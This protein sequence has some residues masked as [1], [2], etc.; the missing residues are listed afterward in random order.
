M[1]FIQWL[2]T[3]IKEKKTVLDQVFV[4]RRGL[5]VYHS[6]TY[7]TIIDRK[8]IY[9]PEVKTLRATQIITFIS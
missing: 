3:F 4:D 1:S 2:D 7:A 6:E 5:C 8:K 9:M